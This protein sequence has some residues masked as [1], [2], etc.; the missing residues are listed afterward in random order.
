MTTTQPDVDTARAQDLDEAHVAWCMHPFNRPDRNTFGR[1]AVDFLRER[2]LV[3]AIDGDHPNAVSLLQRSRTSDEVEICGWRGFAGGGGCIRVKG[4]EDHEFFDGSGLPGRGA[5]PLATPWGM[6][7][8]G[9]QPAATPGLLDSPCR[10][11]V[12]QAA[13]EDRD[14]TQEPG[15]HRAEAEALLSTCDAMRDNFAADI[16]WAEIQAAATLAQ[17]HATLAG[18]PVRTVE[19]VADETAQRELHELR[20]AVQDLITAIDER[21]DY[22]YARGRVRHLLT[23]GAP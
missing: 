21:G 14:P 10:P 6:P 22:T 7:T 8:T 20:A 17:V 16:P 2:G 5:E 11:F 18:P 23:G 13:E 19:I 1:Y 3:V 9:T 15:Y 4:H 12:D